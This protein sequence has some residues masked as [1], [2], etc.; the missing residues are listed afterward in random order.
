MIAAL[1]FLALILAR[2]DAEP[3]EH[4][5]YFRPLEHEAAGVCSCGLYLA[6]RDIAAYCR[7]TR[8]GTR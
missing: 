4:E 5:C 8:E 3:A 1:F 6:D 2:R 7:G